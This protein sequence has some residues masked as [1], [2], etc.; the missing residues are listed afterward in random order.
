MADEAITGQ[1]LSP[2]AASADV[3]VDTEGGQSVAAAD[4]AVITVNDTADKY[5]ISG[6]ASSAATL[7]VQAGDNPPAMRAGLGAVTIIIPAGDCVL[8]VV[9]AARHLQNN[10]TIRIT[11]NTNAVIIGAHRIPNTV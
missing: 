1:T 11:V 6:Y 2:T 9:E 8:F 5:V 10:G 7:T 4:V 3:L